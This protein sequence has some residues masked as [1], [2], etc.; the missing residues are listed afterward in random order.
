MNVRHIFACVTV[1]IASVSAVFGDPIKAT[2]EAQQKILNTLKAPAGFDL[3][4]FASPPDA[5]YPTALSASPSGRELF[6]AVDEQGSLGKTPGRGRVVKLVDTDG[7]GKA[8]QVTVFVTMDHPRGVI[9]DASAHALYVLHPPYLTVYFDDNNDGI[10]DRSEV[11]ATGITTEATLKARGADHTTNN[12]RL[13]IDGW[14]YIAMGDFGA[15]HAVGKDGT[16]LQKHGG[17]VVRIRTDG[18]GL[19]SYSSGQRNI[20]DVAIDPLMNIFTRDNTNDGDGWN[21]RLSY[22]VPTGY[23]GYPSMFKHFRGEFIDCLNDYG[24]GAPCGSIFLDEPSLPEGYRHTLVTVEWGADGGAVFKHPLTPE[25]AGYKAPVSQE[26]IMKLPRGTDIDADGTGHL[27]LSSW[28][29]ASFTYAGPNV[30]YVIRLSPTG[31]RPSSF[32]DL[33]K[34]DDEQLLKELTST[35]GVHRQA[36][37]REILHRGS[38]PVF[39]KGL[40]DI[41]TST[42]AI[43]GRAAAIFTLKLLEGSKANAFLVKLTEMNDLRGLALRELCDRHSDQGVPIE[44]FV[45]ALKDSNP[46]VRLIAAWGLGRLNHTETAPAIVPL[47]ADPDFLVA[48]VAGNALVSLNASSECLK[49][50]DNSDSKL[51]IGA[52]RVLQRLHEPSVV[53]ALLAK[54]AAT[55]NPATRSLI[56]RTLCRLY[57]READWDGTW[58]N[59]RPDTSGP[60]YKTA[61]WE[62]TPKIDEALRRSLASEKPEVLNAFVLDIAKNKI[63]FPEATKAVAELAKS[64]AKFRGAVVDMFSDQNNLTNDQI[65]LLGT[66]ASSQA[67]STEIRFKALA[68]LTRN[69][70]RRAAI[71]AAANALASIMAKKSPDPQLA[72]AVEEFAREPRLAQNLSYFEALAVSDSPEKRELAYYVLVNVANSRL[73]RNQSTARTNAAKLIEQAWSQPESTISLLKAIARTNSR[74]YAERIQKL[75]S[76][77]NAQI[78]SAASLAAQRTGMRSTANAAAPGEMIEKLGYDKTVAAVLATKGDAVVGKELFTRLACVT[79]HTTSAEDAPKGPFLGGIG[80]RYN[81]SELCESIMKPS[82][83]IAQGFETQYFRQKNGDVVEGF[84]TRESGDEIE[85]RNATGVPII[86]KK[87]DIDRRGKRDISIMPEGLVAQITPQELASLIAYL[88]STK[89]K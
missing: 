27:F 89:G 23:Y 77:K 45:K 12:I 53:D 86:L 76:D 73:S 39:T 21:D 4:V 46:R 80:Q 14:I 42:G 15:L 10:A 68:A 78:A 56:Y 64:D 84:V 69:S 57:Y 26:R 58:W 38:K 36:G 33:P 81:R 63:N 87:Q 50:V 32:P 2:P 54:L 67:E 43:E 7:D 8:D 71:D 83:K 3:T 1:T 59:T 75:I 28:I 9:W 13:G 40:E 19:E 20:F 5:S 34:M 52:A 37:Q 65:A 51:A 72:S 35:S 6:V 41:A 82:A 55:Q 74:A 31:A 62:S 17:G 11:L 16:V 61:Q 49:A 47:L 30:G 66:V 25:G 60:Y 18:S 44:P 22:I 70:G 88:E 48:H 85:I 29:G 79:C 24:G